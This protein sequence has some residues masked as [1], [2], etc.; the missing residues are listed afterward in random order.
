MSNKVRIAFKKSWKGE[1]KRFDGWF[2]VLITLGNWM[3]LI[4]NSICHV[5]LDFMDEYSEPELG[6]G[7]FSAY[8]GGDRIDPKTGKTCDVG[9]ANIEF[10]DQWIIYEI[11]VTDERLPRRWDSKEELRVACIEESGS[12]YDWL[13]IV[14]QALQIDGLENKKKKFCSEAVGLKFGYAH[15]SPA[16]L[17]Q[18]IIRLGFHEVLPKD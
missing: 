1:K 8:E 11:D 6:E 9:F 14:G 17:E 4:F 3:D 12:K 5:E 18:E 10:N 2:G 16:K 7:C 13:G 15:N